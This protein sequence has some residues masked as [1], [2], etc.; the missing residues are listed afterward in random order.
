MDFSEIYNNAYY[1]IYNINYY[2]KINDV[3]P[4]IDKLFNDLKIKEWAFITAFNPQS[5]PLCKEENK[6]LN[7]NLFNDLKAY[8]VMLGESG[9][10]NNNWEKEKS[11][12]VLGIELSEAIKLAKKYNQRAILYG[13]LN[14]KSELIFI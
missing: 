3:N 2:I 12:L 5:I 14:N 7:E 8:K 10:L 11:Y 6:S 13:K 1:L 4:L 9:D